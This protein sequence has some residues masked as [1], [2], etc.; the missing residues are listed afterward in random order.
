MRDSLAFCTSIM[1]SNCFG[2]AAKTKKVLRIVKM[3]G[4]LLEMK[5]PV[6]VEEILRS[7]S[8]SGIG[9]S[10]KASE[11]LPLNYQLK[12]GKVYYVIPSINSEKEKAVQ[13]EAKAEG[14]AEA[15]AKAGGVKR[16]KV[17][18]TKKQL[19]QLLEK[20]L[21]MEEV[22]LA[23]GRSSSSSASWEVESPT[24]SNW[25]PKLEAIPEGSE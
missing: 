14:E 12:L 18:I 23:V 24:T 2:K 15:T 19:Q 6:K 25:K 11:F 17:V 3:D 7:F 9:V 22:L 1:V 8:G 16:I 20:Q 21:S 10:E 4:K 13:V 5:S